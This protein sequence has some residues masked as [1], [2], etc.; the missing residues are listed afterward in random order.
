DQVAI[1]IL[2]L[3]SVVNR[4]ANIETGDPGVSRAVPERAGKGSSVRQRASQGRKKYIRT[5][6]PKSVSVGTYLK[7]E[8][9]QIGPIE[10]KG[11]SAK[12]AMTK[13]RRIEDIDR[14]VVQTFHHG[15]GEV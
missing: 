1:V 3:A 4:R 10:G 15:A 2:I 13:A 7:L 9:G 6:E 12:I 11:K 14:L 8:P 5:R